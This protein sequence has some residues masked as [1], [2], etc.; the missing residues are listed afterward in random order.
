[1]ITALSVAT[2]K[3]SINTRNPVK[4]RSVTV[5]TCVIKLSDDPE[6]NGKEVNL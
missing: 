6:S 1:M 5:P 2:T 4:A 3:N